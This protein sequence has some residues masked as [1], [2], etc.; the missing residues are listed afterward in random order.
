MEPP[1]G[2]T[3]VAKKFFPYARASPV[4][5]FPTASTPAV[6]AAAFAA[7]TGIGSKLFC[8]VIA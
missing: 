3:A 8:A 7:E 2:L 4:R 5:T 1:T 6:F